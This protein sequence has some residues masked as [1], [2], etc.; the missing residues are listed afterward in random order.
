MSVRRKMISGGLSQAHSN[1]RKGKVC[2]A[3]FCFVLRYLTDVLTEIISNGS[4]GFYNTL[5]FLVC[6]F[7][8]LHSEQEFVVLGFFL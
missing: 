6:F 8:F 5:H 3:F 4:L 1:T 2:G 7:T